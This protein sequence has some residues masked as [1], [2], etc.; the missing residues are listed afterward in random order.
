M[1]IIRA[2]E[3]RAGRRTDTTEPGGYG[4]TGFPNYD[5]W[6]DLPPSIAARPA[7]ATTT[8]AI[9]GEQKSDRDRKDIKLIAYV[10]PC[11]VHLCSGYQWSETRMETDENDGRRG[12]PYHNVPADE[13]EEVLMD[14]P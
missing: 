4:G 12:E 2:T 6:A 1:D 10:V 5:R 8:K 9:N 7:L 14:V 11:Y 3:R 13:R